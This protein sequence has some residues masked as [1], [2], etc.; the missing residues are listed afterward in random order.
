[1]SR[2]RARQFDFH[3]ALNAAETVFCCR[4]FSGAAVTEL[5]AAMGL[6]AGSFYSAFK[7]KAE[8]YELVLERAAGT[9]LDAIRLSLKH[10]HLRTALT[11]FLQSIVSLLFDKEVPGCVF[12]LSGAHQ[13][14]KSARRWH[15]FRERLQLEIERRCGQMDIGPARHGFA[16]RII[17]IFDAM[18]LQASSGVGRNQVLDL[19]VLALDAHLL[20][21][22]QEW[23]DASRMQFTA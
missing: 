4:G 12:V 3:A 22:E 10:G 17:S 20:C 5:M 21:V 7:S 19:G 9:Y 18:A 14:P 11:Q 16:C 13:W 15:A 23:R 2:G 6:G 1:M 8:L